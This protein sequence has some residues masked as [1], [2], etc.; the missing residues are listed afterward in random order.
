MTDVHT[1]RVDFGKAEG[2]STQRPP[3]I[4]PGDAP[5]RRTPQGGTILQP[6][7]VASNR[8]GDDVS[9]P[10]QEEKIRVRV[11][12][13][14][15]FFAQFAN[16]DLVKPGEEYDVPIS[17]A[18]A[19]SMFLDD[20]SSGQPKSIPHQQ[21]RLDADVPRAELAGRPRHERIGELEA[22]IKRL[23]ERKV[24]A[25]KQLD[26]EKSQLPK[27]QDEPKSPQANAIDPKP[28]DQAAPK[29]GERVG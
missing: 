2:A 19:A 25:Q 18:R 1:D 20:I 13:G 29:P 26:H 6:A 15:E 21:Q 4:E 11:R 27:P 3:Q 5:N 7:N 22:E 10:L 17:M 28:Q 9:N 24:Q 12:D 16:G 14:C 8:P 23:D